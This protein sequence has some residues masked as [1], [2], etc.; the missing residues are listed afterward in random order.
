[1]FVVRDPGLAG[2]ESV[3]IHVRTLLLA[4]QSV[5]SEEGRWMGG[6]WEGRWVWYY[7]ANPQYSFHAIFR[8]FFFKK[9]EVVVTR[10]LISSVGKCTV[11]VC[12]D[13]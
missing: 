5:V 13:W 1:M 3:C 2:T 6:R 12:F 4:K 7:T 9:L 11:W 8:Y 10:Q